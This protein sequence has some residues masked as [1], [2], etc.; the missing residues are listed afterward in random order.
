MYNT[1]MSKTVTVNL[2]DTV[3]K[4]FMEK[5]RLKYG[6]R[7]GSLA[8]VL[9]EALENWLKDDRNDTLVGNLDLL[10]RGINMKKWNFKREELYER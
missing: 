4:R 9:N 7:N 1:L 2:D 6:S 3:E 8:M 10:D 5:A